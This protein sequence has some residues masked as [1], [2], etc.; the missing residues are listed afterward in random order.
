MKTIPKKLSRRLSDLLLQGTG[1]EGD[2]TFP[3]G[4]LFVEERMTLREIEISEGFL[5]WVSAHQRKFGWGN[6]DSTYAEYRDTV[7]R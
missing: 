1:L 3:N 5:N 2:F 6:I 7:S 4:I